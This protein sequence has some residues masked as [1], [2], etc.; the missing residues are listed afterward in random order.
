MDG[1]ILMTTYYYQ[2]NGA[3]GNK[4]I[5]LPFA[6]T[7]TGAVATTDAYSPAAWRSKLLTVLLTGRGSRIWYDRL[8]ASL[9][10]ALTFEN[11][12]DAIAVLKDAVNEAALRWVPE[13]SVTDVL[14]NYEPNTGTLS[15]T[16]RY[17]LPNGSEDQV[18]LSKSSLTTYG[19]TVQVTWNG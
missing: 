1:D 13:I 7:S 2:A 17:Q 4:T 19:D 18:S 12:M 15:I 5:S 11:N 3:T 9:L 6:F 14:Y 8:G 16:V 10:E